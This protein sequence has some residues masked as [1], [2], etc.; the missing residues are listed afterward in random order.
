MNKSVFRIICGKGIDKDNNPLVIIDVIYCDNQK[1]A[2]MIVQFMAEVISKDSY[3]MVDEIPLTT[4]NELF[5]E[6]MEFN[7]GN[8]YNQNVVN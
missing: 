8:N 3:I 1:E 5:N 7:F 4:Y 2:E 6:Q